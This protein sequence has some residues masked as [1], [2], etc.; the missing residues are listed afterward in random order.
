MAE[1]FHSIAVPPEIEPEV[2][3][4]VKEVQKAAGDGAGFGTEDITLI[5]PDARQFGG[6]DIPPAILYASGA[7]LAWVTKGWLDKYVL[8][9]ILERL[10]GPSQRFQQWLRQVLGARKEEG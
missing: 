9:V 10:Q 4:L 7:A 5:K 1:D 2:R 3:I 6:A 8:P